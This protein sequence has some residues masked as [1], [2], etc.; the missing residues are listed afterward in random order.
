MSV[1]RASTA[2][3]FCAVLL[4][5]GCR[6]ES[7]DRK[8]IEAAIVDRLQNKSG[9]DLKTLDVNTTAVNF[10]KNMAYATVSFHPKDDPSLKSGMVMKYTLQREDGKWVVVSVGDPKGHAAAHGATDAI[11][12]GPLPPGHPRPRTPPPEL[13]QGDEDRRS[14]GRWSRRCHSR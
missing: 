2:S 14:P 12:S 13:V 7:R 10:D 4:L 11:P 1:L 8:Q 6:N 3:L 5:A 9:L